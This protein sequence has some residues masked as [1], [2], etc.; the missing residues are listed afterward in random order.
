MIEGDF[1]VATKEERKKFLVRPYE[2]VPITELVPGS[3]S[4]LVKG[5][6]AM[7]SFLTMKAGS[8]FELHSHPH[9]QIMVVIEGYCDEIIENKIYR[10]KKGDV[11]HLPPN[12]KHGAFLKE[13]DCKA[14]DIFIPARDDYEK[15]FH[16]QNP[17]STIAFQRESKNKV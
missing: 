9:E 1:E 2:E 8:V 10:V 7:I 17:N 11:I 3:L 6:R 14:I 4:H 5:E 12:I 15:K 13:A 16:D